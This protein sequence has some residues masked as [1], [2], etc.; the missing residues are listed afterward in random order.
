[1]SETLRIPAASAAAAQARR[2][3]AECKMDRDDAIEYADWIARQVALGRLPDDPKML[4]L[5]PMGEWK[6]ATS[7][8]PVEIGTAVGVGPLGISLKITRPRKK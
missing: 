7:E 4:G 6:A 3:V 2:L 1:M 8:G 5:I